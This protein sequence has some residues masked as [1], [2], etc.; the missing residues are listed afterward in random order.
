MCQSTPSKSIILLLSNYESMMRLGKYSRDVILVILNTR[1]N[2][3]IVI[4]SVCAS[5]VKIQ[6][7]RAQW[8]MVECMTRDRE[9]AGSSLTGVIALCP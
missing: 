3:I 2:L 1:S 8:L 4:I 5:L 6:Q 7:I 9:A